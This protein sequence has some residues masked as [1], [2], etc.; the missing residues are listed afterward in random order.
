MSTQ[1]ISDDTFQEKISQGESK[2]IIVDFWADWCGPC[3]MLAP[4]LEKISE[5]HKD[6]L[7]IYKLNTDENASTAQQFQITSIPCCIL[8]KNGKEVHRVIG[9]KSEESFETEIKPFL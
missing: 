3:K 8:F 4:T 7:I 2:L 6:S 1:I 5:T 9:H